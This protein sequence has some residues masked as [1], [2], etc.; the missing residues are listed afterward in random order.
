MKINW[1]NHLYVGEKARKKRYRIIQEIRKEKSHS[2]IYV[3]TPATNGNNILD[4]YPTTFFEFPFLKEETFLILGIAADYFEAL[5]V[6]GRVIHDL[7][8]KTGGFDLKIFLEEEA[9]KV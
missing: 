8:R 7:Y 2:N 9:G 3:I 6:A 1:Y 4:I 5:E